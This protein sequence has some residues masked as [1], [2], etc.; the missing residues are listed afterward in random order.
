MNDGMKDMIIAMFNEAIECEMTF[1]HDI[2]DSGVAGLS[3]KDM[4]TYL[5]YTADQRL[6]RLGIG[7]QFNVK[8]PFDFME[9]QNAQEL[10][11]FF[12]RRVS[13]YQVGVTGEVAFD[14]SF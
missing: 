8:N 12:E 4:K 6:E 9:L 14:E 5:Q 7:H 11:N 2:L 3:A 1:A 13:A 10:A